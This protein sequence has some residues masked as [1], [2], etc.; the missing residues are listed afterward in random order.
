MSQFFASDSQSIGVS[1]SA[2]ILPVGLK[3]DFL[4][5]GLVRSPFSPGDPQESSPITPQFKSI[6]SSALS[7]LYS[8]ILTAIYD[9]WKNNSF[10]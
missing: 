6:N 5:D 8:P 3:T 10:D 7:F 2:S 4:Y 1:A 9:N